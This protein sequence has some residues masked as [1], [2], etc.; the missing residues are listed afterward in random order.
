MALTHNGVKNSLTESQMPTGYTRPTVTTFSDWE[1]VRTKVFTI[2][3]ANVENATA[4]TTMTNLINDATYGLDALVE[5][6][7]SNDFDVT[8]TVT[9]W[10]DWVTLT[11]NQT[12][13]DAT[14]DW[15]NTTAESYVCTVKIYV[16]VA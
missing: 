12:P 10:S 15:L 5:A 6:E 16:K 2:A 8:N 11:T 13:L 4:S 9:A 14:S 7:I 3:K 1:W